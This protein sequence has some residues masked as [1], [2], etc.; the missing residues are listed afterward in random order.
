MPEVAYSDVDGSD[1]EVM[2]ESG[3]LDDHNGDGGG[4]QS[5]NSGGRREGI[6]SY[7]PSYVVVKTPRNLF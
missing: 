2:V 3:S 1:D 6:R 4:C 7:R 5:G